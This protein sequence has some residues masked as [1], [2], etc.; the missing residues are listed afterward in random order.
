MPDWYVDKGLATLIRQLKTR[1]PGIVIGTIGDPDHSSRLSDHNPEADGSV[2]AA[3]PMLGSSFTK[4]DAIWLWNTLRRYKDRRIAYIIWDHQIVSSTVSPWVVR[5]YEGSDPH[6]GHVHISVNDKHETDASEWKLEEE[7]MNVELTDAQL[8]AI[9]KKVVFEM[10]KA[11]AFNSPNE[12]YA[13]LRALPWRYPADADTS[14]LMAFIGENGLFD[15]VTKLA[16]DVQ[17][18]KEQLASNPPT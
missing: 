14:M 12:L 5:T 3:D 9:A 1:F 7:D 10:A 16:A 2:D 8:T 18:I 15:T 6:T 11:T 13:N 17:A 4:A